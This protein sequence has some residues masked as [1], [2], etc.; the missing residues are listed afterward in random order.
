MSS[1]VEL[2]DGLDEY[3]K[4]L[5]AELRPFYKQ[6][7]TNSGWE[8]PHRGI[9]HQN[10]YKL[11]LPE[12][13]KHLKLQQDPINCGPL[14]VYAALIACLYD[15]KFRK[16]IN[17]AQL[18]ADGIEIPVVESLASDEDMTD[19]FRPVEDVSSELFRPVEEVSS[20]LFRSRST[21]TH[22]LQPQ[23]GKGIEPDDPI[24]ESLFKPIKKPGQNT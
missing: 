17:F 22:P 12:N 24:P 4:G 16:L 9:L 1:D 20:E 8:E 6:S 7:P 5:R 3:R 13:W 2:L 21:S 19:L 18:K 23:E 15:P 14:V 11:A 10:H